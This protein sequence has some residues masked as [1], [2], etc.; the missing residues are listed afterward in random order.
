MATRLQ[1]LRRGGVVE[2]FPFAGPAFRRAAPWL[3]AGAAF[4]GLIAR[5]YPALRYAVWGSDSGEYQF[6]TRQL[7][8]TG[9][10][11]FDYKGWG[12]AYPYFPGFF[13]VSGAVHAVLGVDAFYAT[14]W[15][16]PLLAA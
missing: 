3:L 16:V 12:V 15:T 4:L 13:V 6:L 9:R 2:T 10:V 7:L 14:Q 8:D 1:R 11:L 5:A